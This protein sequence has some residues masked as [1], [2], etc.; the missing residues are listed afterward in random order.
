M[1]GSGGRFGLQPLGLIKSR[2]KVPVDRGYVGE[3]FLN[4]SVTEA[5]H[6]DVREPRDEALSS[7]YIAGSATIS[8]ELC[9]LY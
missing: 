5:P 6:C 7:S 9:K 4:E 3:R 8:N 2:L 1:F